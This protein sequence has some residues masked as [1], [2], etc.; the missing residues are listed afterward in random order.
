MSVPPAAY[1]VEMDGWDLVRARFALGFNGETYHVHRA[2]DRLEIYSENPGELVGYISFGSRHS[3]AIWL[4]GT[5][6]I[7]IA[8]YA[9]H[10]S[11]KYSITPIKDHW[12]QT[13]VSSQSDPLEYLLSHVLGLAS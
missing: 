2:E 10:A 1:Q 8:E 5:P 13:E 12:R 9:I 7:P 6:S 11:G 3:G 4:S